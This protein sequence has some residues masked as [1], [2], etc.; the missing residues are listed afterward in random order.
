MLETS[1]SDV[2]QTAF[3]EYQPFDNHDEGPLDTED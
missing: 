3:M 1:K 2:Q